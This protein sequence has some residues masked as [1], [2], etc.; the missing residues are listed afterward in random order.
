VTLYDDTLN[1]VENSIDRYS[2]GDRTPG[3]VFNDDGS[4]S[5][6]IG[7]APPKNGPQSNWL[8][9][10]KGQFFLVMRIYIPGQE[11]VEQRWVPPAMEKQ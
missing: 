11:V 2:L 4:M 1:L 8:P 10:P 9:A 5:F 6:Y 3:L 7:H